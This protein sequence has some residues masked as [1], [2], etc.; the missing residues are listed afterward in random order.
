MR[1]VD[2]LQA[3]ALLP[4]RMALKLLCVREDRLDGGVV[5]FENRA[6]DRHL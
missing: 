3:R 5:V 4:Q 2:V 1:V 6:H